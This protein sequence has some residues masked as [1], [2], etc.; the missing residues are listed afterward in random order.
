M[1]NA[2][3]I[4]RAELHKTI[5][6]I[7]NDLRGSVD[8]WDFK[9]YVLGMLFYRFISENLT[10][11]LNEQERKA[12]R[13]GFDYA[14]LSDADAEWGRA[15]TVKEKGFYILPSELFAN[16][17]ERARSDSNLNETLDRV[18]ADIEGS[19]TGTESEDDFKGL[20]DDLDVNNKKLGTS[21]ARRN[22]KLVKLLD[23][24]GDMPLGNGRKEGGNGFADNTIDLFGDAYEYLM[25]MYAST[26]GKSGGEF[27]T[28]QEVSELLARIAVVGKTEVNKVYDPACG[29]GSLLLKFVKVL[30]HDKVHQGFF[31]QEISLTTYNLCRINMFLHDVNYEKFDIALGDTLT[32]PKHWDDEPFEAIVSNPPYS[33]KWDGDANPLLIND[34]RYAPAGVLAPKSKADLA[35]TMHILSWLAVNGTAAIVEFP[36]VLYRGGAEQKI[37]KYLIDNNYVDAVIQ[38]PQDLFFGTTIATC[39][40]VLRKSKFDNA[41]LFIDAG[42]EFARSG[43]KN[44]LLPEHQQRILDAYTGRKDI[45]HFARLVE[46]GDIAANGYNIAVSSYVE[47]ADTREEVDITALNAEITRIVARQA[48]LREQIDAIVADLEGEPA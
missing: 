26:A 28:P 4:E 33:T 29:S 24:I 12:G 42:S 40:I 11:Y 16:V 14:K 47:Q 19:A 8:G 7:A 15:E 17:R 25:Q 30:G 38:L 6:R 21:V 46:N 48:E 34:P 9:S 10:S 32:D 31:G 13:P 5:W 22:E 45:E 35:F 36:G 23:A 44:L 1:T 3:E 2:K 41:T 39:I 20:F 37:R 18:F 43:N 27:Y